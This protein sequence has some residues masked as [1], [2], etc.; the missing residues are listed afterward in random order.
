MTRCACGCGET[1]RLRYVRGH[2]HRTRPCLYEVVAAG[3]RTPCWLWR[4]HIDR[5][6][7]ATITKDGRTRL[8]HRVY[9]EAAGGDLLPDLQ[10]DHLCRNRACVNPEHL[11]QVT[12]VVNSQRG[13]QSKLGLSGAISGRLI[14]ATTSLT[15]GQIADILGVSRPAISLLLA[16]HTWKAA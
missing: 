6:G 2:N 3:Y 9:F 14:A 4:G 5:G 11:E 13:R 12:S 16:G 10:L 15:H 1:A 7:Y 8:A